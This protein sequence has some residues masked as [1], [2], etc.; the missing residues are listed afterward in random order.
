MGITH[1][2]TAGPEPSTKHLT[3]T[4]E[5]HGLIFESDVWCCHDVE[6][7]VRRVMDAHRPAYGGNCAAV[8]NVELTPP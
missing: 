5:D 4:C 2:P 7:D 8:V 6:A 1:V 3:I